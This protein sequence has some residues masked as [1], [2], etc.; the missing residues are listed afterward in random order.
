MLDEVQAAWRALGHQQRARVS[1]ACLP[2]DDVER[3]R[4][5]QRA[6]TSRRRDR[7]EEPRGGLRAWRYRSADAPSSRAMSAVIVTR[8]ET[9]HNGLWLIRPTSAASVT[10]SHHGQ[11]TRSERVWRRRTRHRQAAVPRQPAARRVG[12]AARRRDDERGNNRL[13]TRKSKP[14]PHYT[15]LGFPA[16]SRE[17][18]Q[19]EPPR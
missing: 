8:F 17:R 5:R 4:D 2:M 18:T 3:R 12:R 14:R 10:R 15:Q 9:Q 13:A 19:A 7:Q 1:V 16:E 11:S 6:P